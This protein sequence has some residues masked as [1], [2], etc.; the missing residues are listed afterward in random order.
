MDLYGRK[1][2]G[3]AMD[4]NITKE[5]II[6][7]YKQALSQAG[8]PKGVIIHSDRGSIYCSHEYQNELNKNKFI[9]S[10]SKKGDCWDNA[11]IENFFGK[12]K[13]EWL[14]DK[15]LLTHKSAKSVIFW[16]INIYYKNYR[17][18]QSN[19][20]RTPREYIQIIA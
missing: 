16:Y 3:Y 6:T 2:I 8:Y 20:Y 1:I 10:M 15:N 5:L 14:N 7:A 19:D 4:K 13:Q 18:H 9:C 17:L 12:M 11:P